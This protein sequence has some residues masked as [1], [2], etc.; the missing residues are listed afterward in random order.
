[1]PL[2]KRRSCGCSG[3]QPPHSSAQDE[4][5]GNERTLKEYPAE[6]PFRQ[7]P[8]RRHRPE[9]CSAEKTVTERRKLSRRT[10]PCFPR[11]ICAGTAETGPFSRKCRGCSGCDMKP[12]G[13]R[14]AAPNSTGRTSAP[15]KAGEMS[16]S[17]PGV[18]RM[19][20]VARTVRRYARRTAPAPR[21]KMCPEPTS[22]NNGQ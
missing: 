20:H 16:G 9:M 19:P 2:E 22:I 1:M 6:R 11:P 18:F 14:A 15:M 3:T 12:F 13:S 10:A 17:V 8:Q 5:A 7:P 4:T 21:R